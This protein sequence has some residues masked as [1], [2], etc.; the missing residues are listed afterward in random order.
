MS[1]RKRNAVISASS[2][3]QAA[4]TRPE[5]Q[6]APG[7]RPS[8]LDGRV[9]TS[10]GTA[11]LDS[12][13][14]GHAGL[15]L[16]S[17]LLIEEHGTTDFSGTLLKYYAAEGLVQGHQVHVLGYPE[18]WKHELPAVSTRQNINPKK[19]SDHTDEKMKIAWRYESLASRNSHSSGPKDV[20]DDMK[21]VFCH[22][23]DLTKRLAAS[24]IVGTMFATPAATPMSPALE[25]RETP[26]AFK[27]FI[28]D[29]QQKLHVSAPS[30]IHRAVIPN[31]L[32]PSLYAPSACQP[33][34]VLQF[35]HALRSLLRQYPG[36]L[37]ALITLPVS[38]FPRTN[39]M[40]RWTELL[41]DGVLEMVPL[42]PKLG[43]TPPSS[44][45]GPKVQDQSQGILRVHSLP[46]FHERGGGG[47]SN[48]HFREDLSFHMSST[49][50]LVI[51]PY[52]LPPMEEEDHT[53]KSPASTVK[54]GIEF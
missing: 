19:A 36:Q 4:Q 21:A 28:K 34:E 18:V 54:D 39:G 26:S 22:A 33:V 44:G 42:P 13:L 11:S 25:A 48:N 40:T 50:G 53:E 37:T 12:I 29:L 31:L 41:S 8:P 24:S 6:L 23:F 47:A 32:T 45:S 2:S 49:K 5:A 17:S 51:Q 7:L 30:T 10:T 15:P 16:G 52:V 20:D 14:A 27:L 35:L 9:T 3:P 43:A 1:F 46:V 38:L